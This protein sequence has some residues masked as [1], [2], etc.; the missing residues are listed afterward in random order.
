MKIAIVG[1]PGAGK[2]KIARG[3]ARK[4]NTPK[5][6]Q[7]KVVD[8]YVDRLRHRTGNEYGAYSSFAHELEVI[9]VRWAEE[10]AFTNKG[11]HCITVGSL[12][13]SIIYA[14]SVVPSQV[15]EQIMMEDVMLKNIMMQALG[16]LQYKTFDYNFIF[17]ISKPSLVDS[18]TWDEVM[19]AKLPEVLAGMNVAYIALRADIS[20]KEQVEDAYGVLERYAVAISSIT[21]ADQQP[22]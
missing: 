12:C 6:G 16:S 4:L 22:I 15:N 5:D 20:T 9:G 14:T 10:D 13:D 8:G 7:W 17:Y 21:T 18:H 1:P 3:L 11:L 2:T 19:N